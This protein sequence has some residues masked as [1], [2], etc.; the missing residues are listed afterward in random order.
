MTKGPWKTGDELSFLEAKPEPAR[1][2]V[3]VLPHRF[4]VR[5]RIQGFAGFEAFQNNERGRFL[6]LT[7][8]ASRET[9][10]AAGKAPR[11]P[12][13]IGAS[14]MK[15]VVRTAKR[16]HGPAISQHRKIIPH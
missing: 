12:P 16:Y 10:Y 13:R 4:R 14:R 7:N 15:L 8:W 3:L 1:V 11:Q 9:R 5:A 2:M 6:A